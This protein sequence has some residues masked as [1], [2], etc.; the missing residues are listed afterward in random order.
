MCN[1]D[2]CLDNAIMAFTSLRSK[3]VFWQWVRDDWLCESPTVLF[4]FLVQDPLLP[5]AQT[6]RREQQ[7]LMSLAKYTGKVYIFFINAQPLGRSN[8][9]VL[10]HFRCCN[11]MLFFVNSSLHQRQITHLVIQQIVA[12]YYSARISQLT[13]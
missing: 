11:F 4:H 13:H 7:L 8:I 5:V 9:N 2:I 3:Q 10:P 12:Q 1:T 6:G